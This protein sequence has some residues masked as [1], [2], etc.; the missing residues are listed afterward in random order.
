MA[1]KQTAKGTPKKQH[2]ILVRM[3]VE[4]HDEL[5]R[6]KEARRISVNSAV[7]FAIEDWLAQDE[8]AQKRA[9]RRRGGDAA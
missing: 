3:P 6:A 2:S 4:L 1:P 8:L 9:A 5:V 7:L